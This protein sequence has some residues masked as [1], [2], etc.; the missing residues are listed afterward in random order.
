[1]VG[2]LG[3]AGRYRL[4]TGLSCL[5]LVQLYSEDFCMWSSSN[6]SPSKNCYEKDENKAFAG[7]IFRI[8]AFK[9]LAFEILVFEVAFEVSGSAQSSA[10]TQ[11][12][13]NVTIQYH[14]KYST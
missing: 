13:W 12:Y 11:L 5:I 7:T 1:M 10:Y 14:I 8:S 9:V 2:F 4:D 3:P 6:F